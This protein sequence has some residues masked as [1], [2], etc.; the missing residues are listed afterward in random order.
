MKPGAL[1]RFSLLVLIGC[2]AAVTLVRP[3]TA[4]RPVR[5][6]QVR[7]QGHAVADA[8]GPFNALGATLFWGAW[9]YKHDRARLDR[10]LDALRRAGFDYIRVLGSVGG[11]SW[12]DR[13][14]DPRWEDYDAVIAGLTDH[15]YDRYGLRIQWTIFG[16]AT[17]TPEGKTRAALVDR[18]AAMARGREHK[19]FAFEIANEARSNGFEGPEGAAELRALG[20]RLND[21]TPVLI[22][23]TAPSDS[24]AGAYCET[25]AGAGADAATVHYD[26]GF[27]DEGPYRPIK[28]LWAYPDAVD[29]K[30]R[31]ELPK[32]VFNNEPIGPQSSVRQE[33]SPVRIAASFAL[34]FIANNAAY[35]FHSGPGIRGGGA[36]DVEGT[37]KRSANFD[38]LRSF[39]PITSALKA[40]R[41]YLP[42][43]LANWTRHSPGQAT[44][45]ITGFDNTYAATSGRN[46]VA[47]LLDI[48]GPVTLRA[49]TRS[50]IEVRELESG[51][52]LQR[53]QADGGKPFKLEGHEA[54][55]LIGQ[56]TP[57]TPD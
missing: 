31:G 53:L 13:I 1:G 43:G 32:L 29:G 23:L 20:K 3:Q 47:I 4:E 19:V 35:I 49:Q 17:F 12:A 36:A 26:R 44:A 5:R 25:Y 46:F 55:I 48:R 7:A 2:V 40:A 15:A 27:G 28:R 14:T 39:G 33:E 57:S 10:N 45:P 18:F 56:T 11:N 30:C 38:E 51:K 52:V 9:G 16:G 54:L 21:K 37:L 50:T 42:A 24:A 6:G 8:G 22:A 41:D 34:T